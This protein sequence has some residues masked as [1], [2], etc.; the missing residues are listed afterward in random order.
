MLR[1]L[2]FLVLIAILICG[3]AASIID[4][5]NVSYTKAGFNDQNVKLNGLAFLPVVAG[6]GVEGYRRPFGDAIIESIMKYKPS[7]MNF[8]G[9][10]QTLSTLNNSNLATEY[11]KAILT[12]KETSIIDK[13]LLNN[14]GLATK[15]KYFLFIQLGDFENSS[16][17]KPGVL[18]KNPY[19]QT[20]VGLKAYAQIWDASNG[21]VVW[22]AIADVS[23]E[24]SELSYVKDK[25]PETYSKIAAESLVKNF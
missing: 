13:N 17:M 7:N 8:L 4:R 11:S 9:W 22:E 23:A 2:F 3:C 12:Y 16:Q 5:T 18:T 19:I 25:N 20:T 24:S 14:M 21:D 1:Q 10:Q 6:Q 15:T